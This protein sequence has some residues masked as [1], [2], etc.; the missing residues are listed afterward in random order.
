VTRTATV[1]SLHITD[2]AGDE[3][4]CVEE[5]RA[6]AGRGL[7][8]DR[9]FLAT[10]TYSD[11]PE[12]GREV[13][14][15]ESEAVDALE[16]ESA[17]KLSAR[18]TRR[19][20]ATR[21]V[22]LNH[23]IGSDFQVG[24]AKLRG[25]RLCEPCMY[26][27]GLTRAGVRAGLTH[28]GGLR[29]QILVGGRIAVGD[30]IHVA[31]FRA[32]TEANKSL[33]CSYYEEMWNSWNFDAATKLLAEDITFRGS[34]GDVMKGR[35]A[36]CGYML[37]VREAFPD[38]HN[39]IEHL[40]ADGDTVAARLTYS[41]T[42]RGEIFGVAATG[43]KVAYAGVA[44]FRIAAGKVAEGWVLGDLIGLLRQLGARSLP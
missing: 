15:I 9:Y 18:E 27:E 30:P 2:A 11:R 21:G 32:E 19:N 28:R 29:A 41:G 33:I 7:E 17:I 39:T 22:A 10:G 26:L 31:D 43:K 20:I 34:L 4:K 16:H 42:H 38:F 25:I 6:V 14:L 40:I 37:K 12:P 13:T 3:I 35:D 44:I 24:E 1:A 8:G 36:F 23:L 5:V